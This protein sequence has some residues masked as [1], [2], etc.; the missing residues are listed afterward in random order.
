MPLLTYTSSDFPFTPFTKIYSADINTCLND[1]KTLFNTTG[2]DDTNLQ[3]AGITLTTK[4]K[5][6]GAAAGNVL[7][8]NGTALAWITAGL[9]NAFNVIIGSAAQV[10]T[11][12][13]TN[14]TFA[15]WTQADGDR[16]LLL[17]GYSTNE[18]VTINHKVA[19]QGLGNGSQIQGA[20]TLNSGASYSRINGIRT[21]NNITIASGVVG[22]FMSDIWF[23]ST[24]TFVDN[25]STPASNLLS[26]IQE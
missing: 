26:G 15:S 7:G 1:I 6:T 14:S 8:Y 20:I 24:N 22:V 3:N 16:V 23:S 9:G 11:G 4:G 2:L 21:Q 25:N 18:S 17:P 13:A 5:T 19:L 10:L 12:I